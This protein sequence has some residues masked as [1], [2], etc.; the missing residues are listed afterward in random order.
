M[1]ARLHVIL[2]IALLLALA[3]R[4]F[5]PTPPNRA[6]AIHLS[7]RVQAGPNDGSPLV[8]RVVDS[9]QFE[10]EGQGYSTQE[11]Q[12]LLVKI[13]LLQAFHQREC[14]VKAAPA[15]TLQAFVEGLD[16]M[17]ESSSQIQ[18]ESSKKFG[19]PGPPIKP[20]IDLS[21]IPPPPRPQP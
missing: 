13:S 12:N 18:M 2:G 1:R 17:A 9:N 3:Y 15:C 5:M 16:L 20:I 21:Y 4:A 14:V 11:F 8:I 6:I 19:D 10:F 7:E